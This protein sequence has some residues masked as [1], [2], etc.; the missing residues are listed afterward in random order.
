[1]VSVWLDESNG[2]FIHVTVQRSSGITDD[3]FDAAESAAG[4]AFMLKFSVTGLSE[5][6]RVEGARGVRSASGAAKD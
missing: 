1:M 4:L 3:D 6:G 2:Y 5:T